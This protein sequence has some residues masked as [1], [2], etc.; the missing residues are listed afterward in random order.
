M[1]RLVVSRPLSDAE[2]VPWVTLDESEAARSLAPARRREWLSWRAIVRRELASDMLAFAYD[3]SG[4]PFIVGSPLCLAVS[5]C[6]GS[7]AVCLAETRCAVD[8]ERLDR[9]FGRIAD[10]YLAPE[11]AALSDDPLWPAIVW[12]AKECLYKFAGRRRLDFLR[13]MR[14]GSVDFAA[15]RLTARLLGADLPTLRFFSLAGR[16]VVHIVGS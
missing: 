15:G 10:R 8:I 13:D 7:V 16:A 4:A 12:C 2:L 3:D 11:E 14:V 5:H 1:F 9:P 6:K